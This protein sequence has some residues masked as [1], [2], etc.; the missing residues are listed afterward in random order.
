MSNDRMFTVAGV[1]VRKGEYKT[2]F[3][4]DMVVK[5][6]ALH[7][8]GIEDINLIELPKP[9]SRGEAARFLKGT[10]LYKNPVYAAAI[11]AADEKYQGAGTMINR[12]NAV[13]VS[14]PGKTKAEKPSLDSIKAK[15]GK[16]QAETV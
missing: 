14:K 12:A 8:A 3:G 9:M 1:A 5:T 4:T 16:K 10:E 15:A 2:R 7:K 6:K 11:D 13:K